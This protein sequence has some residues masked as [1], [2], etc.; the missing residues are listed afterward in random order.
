MGYIDPWQIPT[1]RRGRGSS[2]VRKDGAHAE[3]VAVTTNREQLE[4][5]GHDRNGGPQATDVAVG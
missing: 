4:R 3:E 2:D 5:A 1:P